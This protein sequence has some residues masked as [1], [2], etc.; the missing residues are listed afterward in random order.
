MQTPGTFAY[1]PLES[2]VGDLY[3]PPARRPPVVCLLHGGFWRMPYGREELADIARDIAARGYAVWNIEYRRLGEP[4]GGWPGTLDDIRTS[5]DHLAVLSDEGHDLDLD[6]VIVVG[7]SAGG[8]LALWVSAKNKDVASRTSR[9]R[10]F[11]AA[12]LAAISDLARACAI[13]AGGG[14]VREFLG[15]GP[16]EVPDRYRA[17]SP[18]EMLPLGVRQLVIHGARDQALPIDLSRTYAVAAQAS[19]DEVT[20]VELPDAGHMDFTDPDSDAH[21]AVCRWLDHVSA[22]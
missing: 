22:R 9:I 19:G 18:V 17:A 15:G 2:Q 7:H 1:G 11:A 20:L 3:M 16:D 13:S 14:A 4:G 6:R 12:G 10:P 21:E 5:V 8:H